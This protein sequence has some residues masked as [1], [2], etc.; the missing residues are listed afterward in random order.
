MRRRPLILSVVILGAFALGATLNGQKD[1]RDGPVLVALDLLHEI[2]LP[3]SYGA[4]PP[5]L[6]YRF[7]FTISE[8]GPTWIDRPTGMSATVS[9][10]G[11]SISDV[12]NQL[13]IANRDRFVTTAAAHTIEIFPQ[14]PIRP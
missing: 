2:C 9:D 14:R 3:V 12:L 7:D 10:L 1:H 6:Q 8:L 5:F 4:R 13:S 11:C